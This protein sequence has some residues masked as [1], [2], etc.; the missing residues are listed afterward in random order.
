MSIDFFILKCFC[1]ENLQQK[2]EYLVENEKRHIFYLRK[3]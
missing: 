2:I 1:Q 3:I